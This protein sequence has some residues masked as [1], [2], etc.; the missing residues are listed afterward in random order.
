MKPQTTTA[1]T[2]EETLQAYS[3]PKEGHHGKPRSLYK[4][5]SV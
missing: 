4:D 5:D 3:T 1:T 2:A